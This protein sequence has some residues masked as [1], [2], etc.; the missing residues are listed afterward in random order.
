MTNAL[1]PRPLQ[2]GEFISELA[3]RSIA[4]ASET[5]AYSQEKLRRMKGKVI[6]EPGKPLQFKGE[7]ETAP[8]ASDEQKNAV[9]IADALKGYFRAADELLRQLNA[10]DSRGHARKQYT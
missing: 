7:E 3:A 6:A 4:L 9:L 10:L 5:N 2:M 8:P 1:P